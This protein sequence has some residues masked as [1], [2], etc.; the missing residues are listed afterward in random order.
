MIIIEN[1]KFFYLNK[2]K[3]NKNWNYTEFDMHTALENRRVKIILYFTLSTKKLKVIYKSQ[4]VS[5]Y[6]KRK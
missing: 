1:I 2:N 6:A 3:T 4:P 5:R